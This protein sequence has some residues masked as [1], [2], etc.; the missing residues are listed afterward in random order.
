MSFVTNSAPV[1]ININGSLD[2]FDRYKTI[3]LQI[4]KQGKNKMIKTIFKNIEQMSKD[5][6]VNPNILLAYFGYTLYCKFDYDQK[7][8]YYYY[9]ADNK[10]VDKISKMCHLPELTLQIEFN[11]LWLNCS[12]CGMKYSSNCKNEKFLKYIIKNQLFIEKKNK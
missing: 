2:L 1:K 4:Q 3:Q 11:Q 9:L 8:N 6:H 5:S 12:S 10:T 7:N